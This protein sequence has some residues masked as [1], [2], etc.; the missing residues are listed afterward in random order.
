MESNPVEK[1]DQEDSSTPEKHTKDPEA[2]ISTPP[3]TVFTRGQKIWINF[4]ASWAAMFSTMSSYIY[5]PAIVPLA[6]DLG[7]T[8]LLLNLTMTSYLVMAAVAPAFMGDLA[9]QTG[10]RPIYILMFTLLI[11]ANVGI[12][13]QNSFPALLVLRMVQA[14]GASG[15]NAVAYGVISDVTEAKERGGFVGIVLLFTDFAVSLGPVIGGSISQELGWRWIFWFLVILTGSHF[16]TMFLFFPETQRNIVG[17]GGGKVSGVY[18]SLFTLFQSTEVKKAQVPIT[19]PA[20]HYPNPFSTLPIL[21]NKE[22]LMVIALYALT[23]AVK[24]TLQTSLGAQCVEIYQLS[25]L[26]AGLIYL[27]SGVAGALGASSTGQYLNRT[28]RRTVSKLSEGREEEFNIDSDEFP[29]LKT[30]LKGMDFLLCISALGTVGYGLILMTKTHIAAM[31]IMQ[32]ITGFTT[33]SIFAI[34]GTLLTDLNIH[35]S[36]TAQGACSIVRGLGA[37][38][39]IAVMQPIA[40]AIGLGGCFAIY[41]ALMLMQFP[42][43]WLLRR[44]GVQLRKARTSREA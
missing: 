38:G 42:L 44:Q 28:Y 35:R 33:A 6:R 43:V 36:A 7:V 11:G 10:R 32:V 17:N 3:F 20:R 21:G 8:V 37:A 13:L 27:P 4:S 34:T 31:I 2:P 18:W 29:I 1:I 22:S 26:N 14:T 16:L 41:A 24:M 19:K 30:R 40:D 5:Y 25:Y 9:D 15:L 39:A 23:Y 12:A